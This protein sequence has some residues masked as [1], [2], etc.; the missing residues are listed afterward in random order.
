MK[1]L[2]VIIKRLNKEGGKIVKTMLHNRKCLSSTIFK[3]DKRNETTSKSLIQ[4]VT[5]GPREWPDCRFMIQ[6]K[7]CMFIWM[8]V[9]KGAYMCKIS[10]NGVLKILCF[11][12]VI[13]T[14]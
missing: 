1:L 4:C 3:T 2:D 10:P 8:S 9:Y 11:I 5:R 14:M 7:T 6:R 12:N 13:L